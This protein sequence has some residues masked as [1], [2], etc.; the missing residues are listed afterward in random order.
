MRW[1]EFAVFPVLVGVA[2]LKEFAREGVGGYQV[3]VR[4]T[5]ACLW[6]AVI[7]SGIGAVHFVRAVW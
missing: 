1:S 4:L 2:P 5:F 3:I 6:T 7:L